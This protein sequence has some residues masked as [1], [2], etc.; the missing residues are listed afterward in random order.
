MAANCGEI[1]DRSPH[2]RKVNGEAVEFH[3]D[4]ETATA[5]LDIAANTHIHSEW[6]EPYAPIVIACAADGSAEFAI[7]ESA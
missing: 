1:V 7:A 4:G 2:S 6:Q 3:Q 5:S